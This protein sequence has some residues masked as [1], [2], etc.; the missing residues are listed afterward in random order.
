MTIIFIALAF[1]VLIIVIYIATS[2]QRQKKIPGMKVKPQEHK[3]RKPETAFAP[4][5]ATDADIIHSGAK[6][7]NA[8]PVG[9]SYL[10][11]EEIP[12]INASLRLFLQNGIERMFNQANAS[13]N[14]Y[15]NPPLLTRQDIKPELVNIVVGKIAGLKN[16]R[17]QHI[18]LNNLLN[19]PAV[20]MNDLSKIIL[21]DPILTAQIL[22]MANSSYFGRQQ[23]I[24]SISHAL[25]LLGL[26]N[27]KN[28][29]YRDGMRQLFQTHS[30]QHKEAVANLWQHSAIASVCASYLHN[31]F[32][33]LN[34][35]TLFTLGIIHD[36]GKLIILEL[37]QAKELGSS[38][39]DKYPAEVSVFEEDRLFGI[40][41]TVIGGLI[42]ENW[43]F[44]DLI[45]NVVTMHHAPAYLAADKKSVDSEKFKYMLTLFI[46][47]QAAKLFAD[48][49]EGIIRTYSLLESYCPLVNKNRL[50][51][52]IID[53]NLLLQIR[54][55]EAITIAEKPDK[56]P[57]GK[58]KP[59]RKILPR[60][61][62]DLA[63][64]NQLS[65][66]A[67]A[68]IAMTKTD[69][70]RTIGRYQ[71]MREIGRGATGT[72]YL[73]MDPLINREVAIKTLRYGDADETEIA[74]NKN[75]LFGEAK[76]IGR[77]SHPNIVTIY[78]VGE[79]KG[80]AYLAMEFLEGED[81]V[82]Y[83]NKNNRLPLTE[84][85]RIILATA[86]ALDYAHRNGIV[87][88]DVKP[89]NIRIL[90]DGSIKVIDFG[91]ARIVETS[92]TST[93]VIIGSPNY[94]SPEQVDGQPLD[95]RSDLFSLG[96]IFYELLTGEKPFRGDNLTSLLLQ[97]KTA[98]P[99]PIST[100]F[101]QVPGPCIAIVERA[102]A[103]DKEQ[104]YQSGR[105]FADALQNLLNTLPQDSSAT[106][107]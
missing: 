80:A 105:E 92:R 90:K 68:T 78:D 106:S 28:I 51:N 41:H 36:I 32:E 47:D 38:F 43:N 50:L 75:R 79:Y 64:E 91:V 102:L 9:E 10:E 74:A 86:L 63:G 52:K 42:L 7:G 98:E 97:I 4:G 37:P 23:K 49:N 25:M 20:Q 53:A 62:A 107:S 54:A 76:A 70:V 11:L 71:I 6:D 21:S 60:P 81:L 16:F 66:A 93:G 45:I 1:I 48:W 13:A 35:G 101:P 29:M 3:P 18:R 30:V 55:T 44:S 95:G 82:P 94:M 46:A 99:V 84:V 31:L 12:G 96:T 34:M 72:V 100:L 77:L 40:N 27:I 14:A 59:Q 8:L 104:R 26:Q 22:R 58:E 2:D 89:G 67:D 69:A 56:L 87:H 83:C 17:A 33:G 65:E 19:D 88:R 5:K 57:A 61:A 103:K 15:P 73:G 24:D 39:L 85:I